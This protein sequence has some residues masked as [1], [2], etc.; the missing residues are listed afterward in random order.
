MLVSPA[1]ASSAVLWA[2]P[3]STDADLGDG[4]SRGTLIEADGRT[5]LR[6]VSDDPHTS[7]LRTFDVP[8]AMLR[9]KWVY[10]T[11]DVKSSDLT[12]RP[13]PWNGIKVMLKID[14]PAG[15]QWPQIGPFPDGAFDWKNVS[16]RI[17]IP[18]EATRLTLHLGLELVAGGA[19][20]D[21]VRIT[22]ASDTAADVPA[23]P[24]DQP[25]FRGHALPALRG[26]MVHPEMTREDLRVFAE[27][28]GGNLIRWQLLYIPHNNP[29]HDYGAY[30]RWLDRALTKL[31]DVIRWSSELGVKVVV[32]LHSPP[33]GHVARAGAVATAGG[34]FW[35][36]PAAQAHF[37]EVWRRITARY[38]D[39][40][41]VI[42]G[43]DLLNEPDDRTVTPAAEDWQALA[44]RAGRAIREVDP[45][46]TLIVEPT[47]SGSAEGFAVF[48][49]LD[50]TN[51]VYSFHLYSPFNYTHQGVDAPVAPLAYPGVIDGQ[52]W[53]R[54]ALEE[55]MAPAIAFAQKHRV[56]LYVGEFSA[57]RWAPGGDRY[58]ADAI[59]IFEKHGWD[60]SY[61]AYR[62]WH[63][64]NLELGPDRDDLT[65][66]SA[67][68]A[69]LQAV[70]RWMRKNQPATADGK[71]FPADAVL[72]ITAPPYNANP[73]DGEDDTAA[74]Q[75]AITDTVDTGRF[76]WFPEGTYDVSDTLVAKNAAG[77]WRAM[78]T[79][80]GEHRE[81]TILRL[82]DHTPGFD[83]PAN[84]KA[85]LMTGSLMDPGEPDTGGGG[86]KAFRNNIINLIIDTGRGNRGAIGVEWAASNWGTVKDATIRSGDGS[87]VAGLSMRR[88]IP[89]PG[90]V[91][92][93]AIEG[94]D[95]GIDVGDIQYGFT[96]EQV[97][98]RHQRKAGVRLD[99]NLLHVRRLTSDN[100]VPAIVT[101]HQESVLT[102]LDSDL[103]GTASG[104]HA[105]EIGGNL[106][107]KDIA[108]EPAA[109]LRVRG[110][111][112]APTE[113]VAWLT[114][115]ATPAPAAGH[116]WLPVEDAPDYRSDDLADWQPVGPRR[117]GEPDDTAA[118]QR[119][120]DAGKPTV[121]F[122]V[123]RTYFVSDTI[124]VRGAV[125]Q[126]LGMG[127]EISLGA[128][129]K[130]FS[131]PEHPRPLFRIVETDGETVFFEHLFLNA[132]YPGVVIFENDSPRTV[133]IG[134][135]GVW[136]GAGR[137][138]R[139]Y[140]N[141]PRATG[142][143]FVE[144][145][146]LPGWRFE[147]QTV[148]ARQFNP[149]NQDGDGVEPQV[150]NRGGRLWILGFKTEGQAPFICTER[151]ATTELYGAYN[152]VSATHPLAV[153]P[154][155]VPY[156]VDEATAFLSF[157]TNN[158]RD[159]DYR[160]YLRAVGDGA[161]TARPREQMPPRNGATGHHSYFL[162]AF[163][164]K[165]RGPVP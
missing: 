138:R 99:R 15:E 6:V 146:F 77:I 78:V 64:W 74:I 9:G 73:D 131:N 97:L 57:L 11:A 34:E 123:G 18:R 130:P 102:L 111:V 127:A 159:S 28:W 158:F 87:G 58:L 103:R 20:F 27:E 85:L 60:W 75:R 115:P 50:L 104:T 93:V 112:I 17:L 148:W 33:G 1:T 76:I 72:D 126:V 92:C 21:D 35:S 143:V 40:R 107:A 154:D 45:E 152:Y 149:E 38:R 4:D 141:T 136:I 68:G 5:A 90:Y 43:F 23:A 84:P 12:A 100:T 129:E 69:R 65:P 31:D 101:T 94:F 8:V 36:T 162:P 79:L 150:R 48:Q 80:H 62:E 49:P 71:R 161:I 19:W 157:T 165:G 134:H 114:S 137:H 7:A 144:D 2:N 110:N 37:V 83:G 32:D 164:A 139:S 163:F 53:D 140:Q 133:V 89:G 55:S 46:R 125:R 106:L 118:I 105:L 82:A 30:D 67:P 47:M 54:A 14:T 128:A 147:N 59:A 63:G 86:N 116:R 91:K 16:T 145:V 52:A 155:A 13:Q 151:G 3:L 119:A 142:R 135:S 132:Q 108:L 10:L 51:V 66:N 153:P 22:P 96:L 29:P 81:R 120:M 124:T 44:A 156:V 56:H 95:Y 41:D 117:D 160:V 39:E 122:P 121:Y 25:I 26:A 88:A 98:V 24:P 113:R 70:L 42:W 61:H 109:P